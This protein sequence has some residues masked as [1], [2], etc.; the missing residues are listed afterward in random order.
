MATVD[1]EVHDAR[2]P[3]RILGGQTLDRDVHGSRIPAH[4][5]ADQTL[6]VDIRGVEIRDGT[7]R[8]ETRGE[9]PRVYSA[10]TAVA[11]TLAS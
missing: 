5:H 8:D 4:I 7:H 10:W 9:T 6:V 11:I 3:A 1:E 2:I